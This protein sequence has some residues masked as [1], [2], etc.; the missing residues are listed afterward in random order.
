M[1]YSIYDSVEIE[2]KLKRNIY[3]FLFFLQNDGVYDNVSRLTYADKMYL[4]FFM[5]LLCGSLLVIVCL[6]LNDETH[7]HI[8]TVVYNF[9]K[10]G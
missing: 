4:Y 1:Q 7:S 5:H 2:Y 3:L 6:L 9:H 10:F 8:V